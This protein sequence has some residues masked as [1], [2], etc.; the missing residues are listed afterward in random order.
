MFIKTLMMAIVAATVSATP[1]LLTQ[2]WAIEPGATKTSDFK[3]VS[4]SI[5]HIQQQLTR[6]GYTPGDI[7]GIFGPATSR[8]IIQ[9]QKKHGLPQSGFPDAGFLKHLMKKEP[10]R[11]E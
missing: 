3:Y 2:A 11:P 6:A 8:A 7:D 4:K 10:A 9:Y 1:V 5:K